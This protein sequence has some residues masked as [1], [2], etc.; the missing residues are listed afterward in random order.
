VA[1]IRKHINGLTARLTSLISQLRSLDR[2]VEQASNG[3]ANATVELQKAEERTA[4]SKAILSARAREAYKRGAGLAEFA[5]LFDTRTV[6][7]ML[8]ASRLMGDSIAADRH[9]YD[10]AVASVEALAKRK[11]ELTNR[12]ED[13]FASSARLEQVRAQVSAALSSEQQILAN[14]QAELAALEEERRREEAALSA[15]TAARRAARQLQLDRKLESLLAWM[16]PASG[17]AGFVPAGLRSS[18]VTT[19][20]VASWYGPGFDGRRASSGATYRQDQLTAASLVLPFGTFLKVIRGG[21]SVVVV[22]TDRGPY[23]PGRVLDLSLAAARAIGI[24]GVTSVEME[25]L[26]PVESAPPF[27]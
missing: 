20:G 9:A 16:E 1:E 8:S 21:R 13:L 5:I 10:Q 3:V 6:G 11:E 26:V 27:P 23:V 4:A 25:I 19:T 14:A 7:E 18:G 24:A 17:P 15:G 12:R 22:I 2:K